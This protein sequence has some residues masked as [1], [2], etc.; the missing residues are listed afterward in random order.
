MATR[1]AMKTVAIESQKGGTGK[2]TIGINVAV[3]AALAGS[4]VVLI[5]L[6]PQASATA[7]RDGREAD[8]P[9]VV[10][11]AAARLPQALEAARIGGAELVI[12]DT[13]PHVEGAALAAARSADLILIPCRPGIL[14]LR[15][16][17][18]T[19]ELV[20][21]ASKPAYVILN[22][23]PPG[24][25]RLMEDAIAAVA[26]HGVG[27]APA[28]LTQRAAYGHALTVGQGVMEFE[29]L[30]RAAAEIVELHAWLQRQLA[31]NMATQQSGNMERRETGNAD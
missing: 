15:A 23:V 4:E 18:T 11:V 8:K 1:L 25:T 22:A 16:I 13:A 19:A 31:G 20:R 7:W 3:A 21:I 26:V 5:D 6:D 10:S 29:P 9:V 14:D 27:V 28:V 30:G 24:A 2:T 12:I 17:G